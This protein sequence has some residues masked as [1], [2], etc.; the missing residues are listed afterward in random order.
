MRK[1]DKGGG[2]DG[3]GRLLLLSLS[4]RYIW[5]LWLLRLYGMRRVSVLLCRFRL[6][7]E[8]M[9]RLTNRIQKANKILDDIFIIAAIIMFP[10][11]ILRLL[12]YDKLVR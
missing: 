11:C 10:M 2:V 1:E 9:E 6:E 7:G 4:W 3:W 12:G 5:I 8:G